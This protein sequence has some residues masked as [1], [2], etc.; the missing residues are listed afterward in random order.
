MLG[1]TQ[2]TPTCA[3]CWTADIWGSDVLLRRLRHPLPTAQRDDRLSGNI[4]PAFLLTVGPDDEDDGDAGSVVEA[5]VHAD[6]ARGQV[7]PVCLDAAPECRQA[8]AVDADERAEGE[9]VAGALFQADLQ[10]VLPGGSLI[11]QQPDR[12]AITRGH[13]IHIAI[14]VHVA[15]GRAAADLGALKR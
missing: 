3:T 10:P 9:A 8:R 7:A 11:E 13:D 15:E 1:L 12:S 5:E 2:Q 4:R 6:V 14:A